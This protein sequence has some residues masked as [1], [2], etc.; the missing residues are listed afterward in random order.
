MG[1]LAQGAMDHGEVAA[2]NRL[3]HR[4]VLEGHMLSHHPRSAVAF[5]A[6]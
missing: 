4:I 6:P 5:N 1:L 3:L 2:A